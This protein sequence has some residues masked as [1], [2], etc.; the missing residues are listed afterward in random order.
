[1]DFDIR[2]VKS[3]MFRSV[4]TRTTRGEFERFMKSLADYLAA[5]LSGDQPTVTAPP[6]PAA[7]STA[8]SA[9]S[10]TVLPAVTIF[11]LVLVLLFQVWIIL[12]LRSM[13]KD[14]ALLSRDSPFDV[15]DGICIGE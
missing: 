14:I 9:P 13:K 8:V 6:P 11:L 1:M 10:S 5:S 7:P 2:F 3:T 12:D 4:I 15:P